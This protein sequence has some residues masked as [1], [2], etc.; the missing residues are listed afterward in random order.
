MAG[1]VA[2]LSLGHDAPLRDCDRKGQ[3]GIFF[4]GG[5]I[6]REFFTIYSLYENV[7]AVT[8]ARGV[9]N[10]VLYDSR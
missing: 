10:S 1:R 5:F 3:R 9:Y 7:E 2:E 8:R 4:N 6:I